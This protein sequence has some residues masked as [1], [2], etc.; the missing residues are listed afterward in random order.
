MFPRPLRSALESAG[1]D[2]RKES[3]AV[4]YGRLHDSGHLYEVWLN[5][6]GSVQNGSPFDMASESGGPTVRIVGYNDSDRYA[7]R[8][9]V[10]D[11]QVVG[12]IEIQATL[13]WVLTEADPEIGNNVS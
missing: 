10:F 4:H 13:P 6:V 8:P 7:P 9:A 11:N 5:F 1:I 3:E 2:W 12:R